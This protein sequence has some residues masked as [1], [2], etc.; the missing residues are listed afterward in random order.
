MQF[1]TFY[2]MFRRWKWVIIALGVLIPLMIVVA[3]VI[4]SDTYLARSVVYP[5]LEASIENTMTG[6]KLAA[7]QPRDPKVV[8][9]NLIQLLRS[10]G[11]WELATQDAGIAIEYGLYSRGLGIEASQDS[12]LI[13]VTWR[14]TDPDRAIQVVNGTVDAFAK[15][16]ED[17]QSQDARHTRE[18]YE[19]RQAAARKALDDAEAA[20]EDFQSQNLLLDDRDVAALQTEYARLQGQERD[21]A[22]MAARAG[23]TAASLEAKANATPERTVGVEDT[24]PNPELERL[25]QQRVDTQAQLAQAEAKYNPVHPRIVELKTTIGDLDAKIRRAEATES[26]GSTTTT[27]PVYQEVAARA[28]AARGEADGAQS[29][30]SSCRATMRTLEAR[31]LQLPGQNQQLVQLTRDREVA[32]VAYQQLSQSLEEAKV[33][34]DAAKQKGRIRVI[35][36]AAA[37]L[38]PQ[39]KQL[40]MKAILGLVA[41]VFLSVVLILLLEQLDNRIKG[42]ADVERLIDVRTIGA[43]PLLMPERN[44]DQPLPPD[45]AEAERIRVEGFHEAFRAL[46]S[47]V[48]LL[49]GDPPPRVIGVVSARNAEG[50]TTVALNLAESIAQAGETVV[51][52]DANLRSPAVHGMYGLPPEPG[53]A[54][55]LRGELP[56]ES[57]LRDADVPGLKVLPAGPPPE[58]PAMLLGSPALRGLIGNLRSSYGWVVVDTPP[59]L[60]F[61]DAVLTAAELDGVLMVVAAGEI[62]RGAQDRLMHEFEAVGASLFGAVVNKVLPQHSD[63]LY[64]YQQAAELRARQAHI[65]SASAPGGTR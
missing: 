38:P 42:P 17:L 37:P 36:M 44:G 54:N 61:V 5:S 31:L 11:V 2:R 39:N 10:R 64:F 47:Q 56:V 24:R 51:L 7:V 1:W 43:V 22:A 15:F 28:A 20:L 65:A 41:A 58:D 29:Q 14:D 35:D 16:Y 45:E 63:A 53:L 32:S 40:T 9:G 25:R 33:N 6:T 57:A 26:G 4:K 13:T 62:A 52:M 19:Q 21:F 30:L 55:V 59:G 12:D 50:R 46:R 27:N 60:A 48:F 34:E 18:V 8:L 23:S 3:T 49:G